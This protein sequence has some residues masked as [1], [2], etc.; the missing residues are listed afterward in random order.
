[1]NITLFF[2]LLFDLIISIFNSNV[3]HLKSECNHVILQINSRVFTPTLSI[4]VRYRPVDRDQS[5]GL[6]QTTL[7]YVSASLD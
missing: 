3:F 2:T 5:I 7:G 1:M 4:G 6:L